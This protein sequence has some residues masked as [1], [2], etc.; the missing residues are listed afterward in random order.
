MKI[1][2]G[3]PEYRGA[4]VRVSFFFLLA[5]LLTSKDGCMDDINPWHQ[6]KSYF[7]VVGFHD[8]TSCRQKCYILNE[9]GSQD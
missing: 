2:D 1:I 7:Q 3:K 5:G 6:P 8:V 4:V 9:H